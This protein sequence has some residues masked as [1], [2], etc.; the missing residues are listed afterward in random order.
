[1]ISFRGLQADAQAFLEQLRPHF[2]GG[3]VEPVQVDCTLGQF[4]LTGQIGR[5]TAEGS[6][7]YRCANI[8]AKDLLRM[9]VQHV[10]LNAVHSLPT[11]N[12]PPSALQL[13]RT[14]QLSGPSTNL[15]SVLVGRDQVLRVPPLTDARAILTR[16]LDIYW[17]GLTRPLKLFPQTSWAYV[18]ATRKREASRS[19]QDPIAVARTVWESAS[20]SKVPGE[21]EDPYFDLCFRHVDPLDEEF[22]QTARAVFEPLVGVV[23]EVPV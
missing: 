2:G 14:G 21:C 16:L 10:I 13:R 17:Q 11:I 12:H 5:L 19:K 15:S 20:F 18:E 1:V 3:Y 9:W 7:H 8:K 4:H 23:E 6:L 22:Q